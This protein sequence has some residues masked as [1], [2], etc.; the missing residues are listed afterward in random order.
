MKFDPISKE[1][2]TNKGEFIKKINCPF[3]MRWDNLIGD[4][5]S[6]RKCSKCDHRIIDTQLLTDV[7]LLNMVK[8]NAKTCLKIDLN[9]HNIKIISN[10]LLEEK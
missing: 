3:N 4:D 9:Q 5:L 6:N 7:E 1:V 8:E 10:G 2:L